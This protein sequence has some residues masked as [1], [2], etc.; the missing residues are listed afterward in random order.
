MASDLVVPFEIGVAVLLV[1]G[2]ILVRRGYVRAHMVIQSSMV[3]VNIPV[4][5]LWMVPQYIAYVLPDLAGEGLEPA[6]LVPTVMLVAGAAA[7]LLGIYILLVAGTDLRAGTIPIPPVQGLD[8]VRTGPV[9]VG[10]PL[11]SRNLLLLV[12]AGALS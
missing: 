4:V 5:L 1:V 2:M 3:L 7:E 10:A 6:Y 9:V 8:A 11:R 12:H